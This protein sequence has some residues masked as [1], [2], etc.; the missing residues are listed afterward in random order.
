MRTPTAASPHTH[1][2]FLV[3]STAGTRPTRGHSSAS[4]SVLANQRQRNADGGCPVIRLNL[5]AAEAVA[6]GHGS[7]VM[8]MNSYRVSHGFMRRKQP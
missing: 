4:A 3:S 7:D 6:E 5:Q 2:D 8:I 1:Y